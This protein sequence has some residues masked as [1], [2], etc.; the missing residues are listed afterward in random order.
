MN[1]NNKGFSLIELMIVVAIVGILSA[2]ALPAYHTY[3]KR[4]HIAEGLA[5]ANGAKV[6]ITDYYSTFGKY[7][8]D[9]LDVGIMQAESI[10]SSSVRSIAVSASKVVITYNTKVISGTTV[11]LSGVMLGSSI[12]WSCSGGSVPVQYRP[13]NCR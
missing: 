11:E 8:I 2:I 4:A 5:L 3:T 9:N 6:A 12:Q 13:S 10:K 1:N 7:P